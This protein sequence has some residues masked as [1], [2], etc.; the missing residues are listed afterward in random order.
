MLLISICSY[1]QT[2]TQHISLAQAIALGIEN[3]YDVQANK[4]NMDL[5]ENQI[6][7]SKKEWLPDI[8]ATGDV[9]YNTQLQ[10]M[11]F[12]DVFGTGE[13]SSV[14]LGTTNNTLFSLDLNQ[15]IYKPGLKSDI[16]IAENKMLWEQEKNREQEL[17]MKQQIT[18]AYLN[19]VLKKEQLRIANDMVE[20]NTKYWALAEEKYLLQSLI[21]ND[22]LRTKLDYENAKISALESQQ[23]YDLALAQLHYQ[24]N[25][26]S[27]TTLIL[28]DSLQSFQNEYTFK[29][30]DH[31]V[32]ERTE[33]KQL[34]FQQQ[35]YALQLQKSK[36]FSLPTVSFVGNYSTQFQAKNYNYSQNLWSPFNYVGLKVELPI[37]GNLKNSNNIKDYQLKQEQTALQTQQKRNDIN[38]EINT[39]QM[40]LVNAKN[41]LN[42]T[43]NNLILSKQLHQ[44][45]Q[46]IYDL[47]TVTYSS[48]L[49][50]EKAIKTAEEKYLQAVYKF[51]IAK[52][53][54]D[55]AIGDL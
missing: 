3:R 45:Q 53:N 25:T 49:D 22:L 34:E 50:T 21:E 9:K 33:L 23:N 42:I 28:T 26:E 40:S 16:K 32:S 29:Q 2:S 31:T 19:V 44:S 1:G 13:E 47:G 41:T 52:V 4:L 17:L 6:Q 36:Q 8:S 27:A 24:L 35:A 7:K 48:V 39:C 46:A 15:T 43:N 51:L 18:E 10:T 5:A 11:I 54:Y 38:N 20:R 14:A 30:I 55:K 12:P 37:T